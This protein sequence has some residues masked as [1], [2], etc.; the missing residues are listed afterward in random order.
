MR[1]DKVNLSHDTLGMNSP[2]KHHF[3]PEFYL[4]RWAV[5]GKLY[6]FVRPRGAAYELHCKT[7]YPGGVGWHPEL[8][9]LPLADD[10]VQRYTVETDF[11]SKIDNRAARAFD[12]FDRLERGNV[13]EYAGL[14]QFLI[15][16][17][18]R[19]PERIDWLTTELARKIGDEYSDIESRD[20]IRHAAVTLLTDIVGSESA[21]RLFLS[22]KVFRIDIGPSPF[23]LL[24]SDMPI[25]LSNGLLDPAGFLMLPAGPNTLMLVTQHEA[26]VRSFSEQDPKR[27][28]R[29]VNDA[30]VKQANCLVISSDK[31][32][33]RFIDNRFMR[34]HDDIN[35]FRSVD[36]LVRW[37]APLVF[38]NSKIG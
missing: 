35:S 13:F 21:I 17:M 29:A 10:K 33:L 18:H 32:Q 37:K 7:V 9:S 30:I 5:D 1:L 36:G 38:F 27:L 25:M 26:V 22:M 11:F 8:Y 20:F 12:K 24:A 23:S 28:V 16:L 15:S 3:L 31:K 2:K 34:S 6:R 19:T 14:A 4:A